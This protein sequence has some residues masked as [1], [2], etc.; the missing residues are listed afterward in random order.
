VRVKTLIAGLAA[1][2]IVSLPTISAA[3][4][5]AASESPVALAKEYLAAYSTFDVTIMEPFLAEEMVFNDPTSTNQNANGEPFFFEGK[6]AVLKGL[7]DIAVMYASFTLDYN[8]ERQYESHGV[9]VFIAQLTYMGETK[10][11]DKFEGGAPI[12]TAITIKDGK[13]VRHMDY[14]DYKKNAEDFS[15]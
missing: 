6:Q 8:I 1:A 3:E 15:K 14:F 7:G 10:N 4:N 11:G 2:A 9:V 13:V 5:H 12:V